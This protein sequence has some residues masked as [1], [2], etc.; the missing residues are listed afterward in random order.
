[1]STF[2]RKSLL[3]RLKSKKWGIH[4]CLCKL[5]CGSL[6]QLWLGA[7]T[8]LRFK[9]IKK[10]CALANKKIKLRN[11]ASLLVVQKIVALF[12]KCHSYPPPHFGNAEFLSSMAYL[13]DIFET[14][15][16]LDLRMQGKDIIQFVNFTLFTWAFA[17]K[18]GNR[19][20]KLKNDN[21]D[22]FAWCRWWD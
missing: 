1:M 17:K 16:Q 14:L 6:V 8:A 22:I 19:R 20:R 11:C 3:F 5:N 2:Y 7:R 9:W 12:V 4:I 21:A 18:L 15:N 13:V 10:R